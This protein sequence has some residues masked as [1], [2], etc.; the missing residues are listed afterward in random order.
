[1]SQAH[2]H[3]IFSHL[4]IFA[5]IIGVLVLM[6]GMYTRNAQT[7]MA[8]FD[9]FIIAGIGAAISYFTGEGAEDAVENLSGISKDLIHEHEESAEITMIILAVLAVAA[10]VALIITLK[11]NRLAG[12]MATVCL[13]IALIGFGMSVRTGW[14]GGQI[15]HTE[16][17]NTTQGAT[18][19][20]EHGDDD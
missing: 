14:L 2:L 9:V 5:S 3:L 18:G 11:K 19:G 16:I 17:S 10:L 15:R 7:K 1:M 4:P 20:A 6:H 8:S 13:V 12:M